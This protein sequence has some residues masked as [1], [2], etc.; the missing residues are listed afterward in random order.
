MGKVTT[1]FFCSKKATYRVFFCYTGYGEYQ[2]YREIVCAEHLRELESSNS[3]SFD[4][5]NAD[6]IEEE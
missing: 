4:V 2:E 5:D 3:Y 6:R 1:C